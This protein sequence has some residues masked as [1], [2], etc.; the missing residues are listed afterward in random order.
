MIEH[1]SEIK[2]IFTRYIEQDLADTVCADLREKA[3][4][5]AA[6]YWGKGMHLDS[7]TAQLMS[8]RFGMFIQ[9]MEYGLRVATAVLDHLR[10]V[11]SDNLAYSI[12]DAEF[13][14]GVTEYLAALGNG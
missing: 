13:A 1:G 6:E 4:S 9:G 14:E 2:S 7:F 12:T 10:C 5:T 11:N 8:A 3:L